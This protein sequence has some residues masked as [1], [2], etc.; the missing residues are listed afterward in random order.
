MTAIDRII[1]IGCSDK[2]DPAATDGIDFYPYPGPH[3]PTIVHDV[4]AFPWPVKDDW[5]DGAISHQCIEHLPDNGDV[6]GQDTLF[7]FFDE[8]WRILKAGGTFAFDVP[9][10]DWPRFHGDP[11]HRRP[12]KLSAF[13]FLWNETRDRLYPRKHWGL[14]SAKV[15]REYG[16]RG[17]LNDWH[18]RKHLPRVDDWLC[19]TG[20]GNPHFI[21][22]VLRKPG[23]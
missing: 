20:I 14:V 3:G 21:Y 2:R 19:R 1:D 7:R 18:I 17:V 22:V 16:L 8:V 5:Y 10:A 4:T 11:T 12:L 23:P 9:D 15:D 6:A 13:D